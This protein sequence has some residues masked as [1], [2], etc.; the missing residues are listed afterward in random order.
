MASLRL[1]I[2]ALHNN[3]SI[4]D[5]HYTLSKPVGSCYSP[6]VADACLFVKSGSIL[7]LAITHLHRITVALLN[8]IH[9][10]MDSG[11]RIFPMVRYVQQLAQMML[12]YHLQRPHH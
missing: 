2:P 11:Q 12:G 6:A 4:T 5:L 3:T 9:E 7:G 1:S 10:M 8:K